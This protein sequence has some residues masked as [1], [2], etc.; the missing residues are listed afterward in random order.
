MQWSP[1]KTRIATFD[2]CD[3]GQATKDDA[4]TMTV[5]TSGS[6]TW[7][8]ETISL[9]SK[10]T[11]VAWP[12]ENDIIIGQA[13]FG[14]SSDVNKGRIEHY[15]YDGSSDWDFVEDQP[16]LIIALA[17]GTWVPCCFTILVQTNFSLAQMTLAVKQS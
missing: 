10:A 2:F 12:T 13:H 5:L 16:D 3:P 14:P 11:A 9:S 15:R 4:D 17:R 8:T 1:G 6:T 7:G